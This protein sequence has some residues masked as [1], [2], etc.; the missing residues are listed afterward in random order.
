MRHVGREG[1]AGVQAVCACL[2]RFSL[3]RDRFKAGV[4]RRSGVSPAEFNAL[5][6][7]EHAGRPITP[8]ELAQCVGLTSGAVTALVDRLVQAGLVR[9]TPHP[10]DRRSVLLELTSGAAATGAREVG[11]FA[12]DIEAV[13]AGLSPGEQAAVAAF[14]ESVAEVAGRHAVHAGQSSSAASSPGS[15]TGARQAKRSHT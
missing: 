6:H 3:E 5:D 1:A 12:A 2:R 15:V 11:P 13:A 14:L 8:G 7:L 4:A 10:R 9:R